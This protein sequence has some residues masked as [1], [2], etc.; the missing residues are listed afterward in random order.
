MSIDPRIVEVLETVGKIIGHVMPSCPQSY[1]SQFDKQI[2]AMKEQQYPCA[3]CGKLR[4]KAEGGATFT[5][6]DSCFTQSQP[7]KC[8]HCGQKYGHPQRGFACSP[9]Q[10]QPEKDEAEIEARRIAE[11]SIS[12]PSFR[13]ISSIKEG[14]ARGRELERERIKARV[15]PLLSH[16]FIDGALDQKVCRSFAARLLEEKHD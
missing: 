13:F 16:M 9:V 14:I 12:D 1:F 10:S 5:L 2:A 11:K 7:E 6:C 3:K 4:T 15:E 8:E